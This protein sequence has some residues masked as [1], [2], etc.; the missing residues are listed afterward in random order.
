MAHE[1]YTPTSIAPTPDGTQLR[2]EW[3]DGGHSELKPFDLRLACPCAGCV[4]EMT[5]KPI[6]DPSRVHAN[7]YPEEIHYVGRYAL[8]FNWSDGHTT[9]IYPFEYL[10]QMGDEHA[11]TG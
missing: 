3:A 2:I 6:L 10:R 1:R 8:Q 9:G 4:D 5:G 7:V 11:G